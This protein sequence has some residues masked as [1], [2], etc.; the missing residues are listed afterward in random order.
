MSRKKGGRS[1]SPSAPP[2]T[3]SPKE[4]SQKKKTSSR[5]R[6]AA[7]DIELEQRDRRKKKQ[8]HRESELAS[9]AKV[10]AAQQRQVREIEAELQ[11]LR[12]R[13]SRRAE[14]DI[15]AE[16]E[17]IGISFNNGRIEHFSLS[18]LE[19]DDAN[20][21][22]PTRRELQEVNIE[23]TAI[24]IESR[25]HLIDDLTH[26]TFIA[27][28]SPDK[29]VKLIRRCVPENMSD[30]ARFLVD[31]IARLRIKNLCSTWKCALLKK[32]KSWIQGVFVSNAWLRDEVKNLNDLRQAFGAMYNMSHF[33]KVFS[34]SR[35]DIDLSRS[36]VHAKLWAQ[37]E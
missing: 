28:F 29:C 19:G 33:K 4:P 16:Q 35:R 1:T 24:D 14:L 32:M 12:R 8:K 3:R 37:R 22:M 31:K 26:L 13:G 6:L 25:L 5:A 23:K 20:T 2:S 34:F 15:H 10:S 36:S 18:D 7:R 11:R 21:A 27:T 9:I 30:P 17:K